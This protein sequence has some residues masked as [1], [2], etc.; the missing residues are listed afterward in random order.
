MGVVMKG[1]NSGCRED[2]LAPVPSSGSSQPVLDTSTKGA[3][4]STVN[5]S[6]GPF[7]NEKAPNVAIENER[8]SFMPT[9]GTIPEG[10]TD[11]QDPGASTGGDESVFRG[12]PNTGTKGG[13][14]VPGA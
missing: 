13:P 2:Y 5:F 10:S 11:I 8:A 12:A 3:V 1:G 6:G 7:P 14:A 4:P 9:G